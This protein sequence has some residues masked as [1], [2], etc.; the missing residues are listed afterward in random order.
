MSLNTIVKQ[1]LKQ[2]RLAVGDQNVHSPR[3]PDLSTGA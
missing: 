2:Y 3:Q 1:L